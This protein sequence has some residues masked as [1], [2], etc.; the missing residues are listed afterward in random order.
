MPIEGTLVVE[1]A[2]VNV[3]TGAVLVLVPL[4]EPEP[5][6]DTLATAVFVGEEAKNSACR[7]R[8]AA[9]VGRVEP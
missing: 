9:P 3:D 4:P 7:T 8:V 1:A 2:P 6:P 5:D